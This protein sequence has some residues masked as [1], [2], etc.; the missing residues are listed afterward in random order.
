MTSPSSRLLRITRRFD[1]SPERV[2]D[3]WLNP[4]KARKWLFTSPGTDIAARRIEI[5]PRVGGKWLMTNQC[6]GQEIEGIGEYL[7]I[8]RPHRLVITFSMPMFDLHVD[9]LVVE[10]V[11]DGDGCILTLTHELLPPEDHSATASGWG[12]M[13]DRLA[14]TL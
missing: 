13:F 2:F 6:D 3:A 12:K 14:E 9:R 11:L 10:I 4:E 1:A 5:D 8:D 7:E